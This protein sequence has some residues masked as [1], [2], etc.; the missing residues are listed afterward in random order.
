MTIYSTPCRSGPFY[1][2]GSTT[3]FGFG[4]KVFKA[5]DLLVTVTDTSG[6]T[7]T[8]AIGSGYSVALSAN[9]DTSPG[10][11]I[12]LPIALASGYAIRIASNVPL[13]Q[14]V[15]LT[16]YGGFYPT[17]I[18]AAL[19]RI[20]MLVQQ[21][22]DAAGR[23]LTL[24]AT[25]ASGV[26]ALLPLPVAKKILG[27]DSNGTSIRNYDTSELIASVA[28]GTARS[29]IFS[30][31]GSQTSFTLSANPTAVYNLF[32]S[33]GGS[34]YRPGIDYAWSPGSAL[35]FTPAPAS[36]TNNI[37][38]RYMQAL[39]QIGG[40][41]AAA[42][43]ATG[44]VWT[45]VQ[46]YINRILSKFGSANIGFDRQQ[47]NSVTRTVE[48][49][50]RETRYS[51]IDFGADPTGAS[52]SST[53]FG[54][55]HNNTPAGV[56]IYVPPGT[57]RLDFTVTGVNRVWILEGATLT[58][59]GWIGGSGSKV[60]N[61]GS[62][63]R[64]DLPS[65]VAVNDSSRRPVFSALFVG[66]AGAGSEYGMSFRPVADN[67]SALYF[68]NAAG[69][70][71]GSVVTSATATAYNTSSDYRLKYDLAPLTGS[72]DFIDALKPWC[73]KW[74]AD[75]SRFVGFIAHEL[76]SISSSSVSGEKDAVDKD[77]NPIYQSVAY[78]SSELIANMVAEI[79]S[80][81][82]RVATLETK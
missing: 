34:T 37:L 59:V 71:V 81:R 2:N 39:P 62:D 13:T 70:Q 74:T 72:G 36:G 41:D 51:V 22:A 42:T 53:A 77:G 28:T 7:S 6:I 79:Q 60:I 25:V 67:T 49:V 10:G 11:Y 31:N 63:G 61:L 73:G 38:A 64:L 46:E 57:Y 68:A 3:V 24:P 18:N 58:G 16:N 75:S 44:G 20:V 47:T 4:F 30:G 12:T 50:L 5:P 27:W 65:G 82:R 29:D 45:T 1:G 9:Q 8:L 55:A 15:A 21:L 43:V 23:A 14:E 32:V 69:V 56:P 78:G 76:A 66:F 48:S 80:L 33:V 52:S 19:D 17:V 26:S 40:G 35:V 54:W